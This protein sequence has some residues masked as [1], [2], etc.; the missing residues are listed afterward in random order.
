MSAKIFDILDQFNCT[1][2]I[3]DL[4]GTILDNNAF[5]LKAWKKYLEEMGRNMGEEEYNANINGRTNKDVIEY[6]YQRKM[7]DDE[8]LPFALKK[9]SLYRELYQPEIKPVKGLMDMLELLYARNI[10][11]AIATS[12]IQ[13]NIDFMF[14]NVP[15]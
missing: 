3:F 7:Q 2:I 5:H 1:A 8:V 11:M 6:I 14:D 10:P 12:G 15:L 9:E 13:V 4:D